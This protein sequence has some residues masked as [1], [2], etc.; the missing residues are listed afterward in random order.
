MP[1]L[2]QAKKALRKSVKAHA[3]NEAARQSIHKVRKAARVSLTAKDVKKAGAAAKEL[4]VLVDKAAKR[5]IMHP[6]KAARI[7]SRLAKQ[8]SKAK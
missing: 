6:N 5:G 7:K 4:Q 8:I 2:A 1:N 3:R